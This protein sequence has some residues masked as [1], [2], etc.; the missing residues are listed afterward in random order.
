MKEGRKTDETKQSDKDQSYIADRYEKILNQKLLN[1]KLLHEKLLY[2]KLLNEN[3]YVKTYNRKFHN[4]LEGFINSTLCPV[5][6]DVI[7]SINY[8]YK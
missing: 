3:V 1:E 8:Y 4:I 5:P 6:S 2:E 7:M